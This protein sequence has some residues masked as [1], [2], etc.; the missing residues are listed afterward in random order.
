MRRLRASP[1]C[2]VALAAC[3]TGKPAAPPQRAA[4]APASAPAAP[5]T[6][7]AAPAPIRPEALVAGAH[8]LRAGGDLAN[9]RELLEGALRASPDS[10]DVRLELAD[11]LLSDGRENDRVAALLE[12]VRARDRARWHLLTARLAEARGD[13]PAA[14][15]AYGRALAGA[16]DPD[17]RFRRALALERLGRADEAIAELERVRAERPRDALVRTKLGERYEAASRFPEAE[18]ELRAAAEAQPERAA[19]WERLAGFY[20]RRGRRADASAALARARDAGAGI[21]GGRT[22]RPLLPSR[23]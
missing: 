4:G 11:L 8:A 1:L 22:L 21:R 14:V 18:S 7:E 16:D 23:L 17:A 10:D 5:G 6:R 12:A 9:A 15:D 19:G 2:A 3:A 20:E 13:D